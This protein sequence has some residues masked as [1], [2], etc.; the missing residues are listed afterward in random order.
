[1]VDMLAGTVHVPLLVI[2]VN[3]L[4]AVT[5]GIHPLASVV[6]APLVMGIRLRPGVAVMIVPRQAVEVESLTRFASS[7]WFSS[8]G[9]ERPFTMPARVTLPL[10]LLTTRIVVPGGND[11]PLPSVTIPVVEKLLYMVLLTCEPS[12]VKLDA[13]STLESAGVLVFV[14]LMIPREIAEMPVKF[15]LSSTQTTVVTLP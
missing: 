14:T 9:E 4:F 5:F 2:V 3:T 15:P 8:T 7:P 1:M 13:C 11:V 12:T 6:V 10:P